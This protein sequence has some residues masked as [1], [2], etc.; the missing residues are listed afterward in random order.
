[1]AVDVSLD[2][3][4]GANASVETDQD[5]T[6]LYQI[7]VQD[8]GLTE[9]AAD[10]D[11]AHTFLHALLSTAK[12]NIDAEPT[13]DTPQYLKISKD[14]KVNQDGQIVDTFTVVCKRTVS[15]STPSET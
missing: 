14:Q 12:A 7:D 6:D 8:I 13:A 10:L 1:M 5:G 9:G 15:S 2:N 4:F 3:V 11:N